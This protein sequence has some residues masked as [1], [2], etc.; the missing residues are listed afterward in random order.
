MGEHPD[1]VSIPA[2]DFS[3]P[4]PLPIIP[5]KVS[6][7]EKEIKVPSGDIPHVYILV[8][9]AMKYYRPKRNLITI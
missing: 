4:S 2:S 3:F 6:K 9:S 7:S 1:Y 5:L 8:H